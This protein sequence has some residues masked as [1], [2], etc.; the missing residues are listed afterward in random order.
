MKR[1]ALTNR[2]YAALLLAVLGAGAGAGAGCGSRLDIGSNV[3]WTARHE[4]GNFDEWIADAQG[5][6]EAYPA[7]NT[8]EVSEEHVH[9]GRYAAKLT[10]DATGGG[11]Q[12]NSGLARL[13][14]LPTEAYYSAWYFLP[15]SIT[16]GDFWVIFKF[17]QRRVVD[18]P[19]SAAE[20]YDLDLVSLAGGEMSVALYDHRIAADVPLGVPAPIVPVGAWFHVEAFYRNA[21]DQTGRVTYW[22]DGRMIVDVTGKPTGPNAWVEWDACNVGTNLTPSTAVVFID[23]AAM[24]RTRV[25]PQ[26]IITE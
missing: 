4:R 15:R 12:Q 26:G 18:D 1:R 13:G 25:G 7:P 17:R 20:L 22:L 6:A 19:N 9:G 14:I 24:S 11:V 10:I 21:P 16:V 2:F 23:D 3:L 5:H 8:I